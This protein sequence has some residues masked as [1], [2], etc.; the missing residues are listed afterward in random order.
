MTRAF[1]LGTSLLIALALSCSGANASD[2]GGARP[3]ATPSPIEDLAPRDAATLQAAEGNVVCGRLGAACEP[4]PAY[5]FESN[6]LPFGSVAKGSPD[7][8]SFFAVI[9]ETQTSSPDDGDPRAGTPPTR[10]CGGFFPE[11][12]RLDAQQ[13][14]GAL[15][16]FASR[17]GCAESHVVYAGIPAT[18]NVLAVFAGDTEAEARATLEEA[19]KRWSTAK[20]VKT[21]V[22]VL[23][24][25]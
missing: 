24:L 11:V 23:A 5:T 15:R 2:G 22:K 13:H 10:P 7:S 21:Y 19:K 16:V 25:D 18:Q 17:H 12:D 3:E 8:R 6:E 20:L 14:F 4:S 9:L 1:T